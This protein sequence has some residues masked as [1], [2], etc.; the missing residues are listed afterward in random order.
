[1][2]RVIL[3]AVGLA[4]AS[5][6]GCDRPHPNQAAEAP[7]HADVIHKQDV[8]L[9][10]VD[11]PER[12]PLATAATHQAPST[13]NV[14]GAVN[15]DVSRMIPVI[16][17]VSGRVLDIHVRLGDLVKR[18][19]LV[20][21]VQSNDIS[22]AFDAYLKAVNDEHLANTQFQRA[23]QLYEHGAISKGQL[24]QAEDIAKNA[25]TDL[26]S[27]QEQVKNLGGDIHHPSNI[28]DIYS[29]VSGVVVAQ[30]VTNAAPAGI[31][32]AGSPTAFMI[33]DLSDIWVICDVYENDIAKLHL[34]QKAEIRLNA[35]PDRVVTGTVSDIG[36]ILDPSIRT[37]KVRIEVRNPGFMRI[38][39]FATATFY[40]QGLVSHASVPASAILHLHD[41]DWIYVPAGGGRFQR[42]GV[43]AGAVLP[44]GK[45]EIVSGINPG[46]Q[47][48]TDALELENTVD[49]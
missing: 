9:I 40:S 1:M 19:Q 43:V 12:F 42:L 15:P 21:R 13:L 7:P 14:T 47:V 33:A 22:N 2:K 37:A 41:R 11:R 4:T 27:T 49:Q 17:L 28:V 44:N 35:Y 24:D 45:Q 25:L 31:T 6:V 16:S 29:P 34:G 48:V 30:N 18:G 23:Q 36:A 5:L 38:G 46:E 3:F 39:M 26:Q 10:T 8:N 32:F 20:L